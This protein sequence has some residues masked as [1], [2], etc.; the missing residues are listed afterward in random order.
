M[1]ESDPTAGGAGANG[2]GPAKA[3]IVKHSRFSPIWLIP[4]IAL[5]VAA[6]VAYQAIATRG[7][8]VVV[9]F[10]EAQGIKEG[11]SVVKFRD[12]AV[13]TVDSI[14]FRD[15]DHIELHL[16]LDQAMAP[17]LIEGSN[18]WV[19]RPRFGGG[20]ISGLETIVSGSFVTFEP[21][22]KSGG[23]AKREYVGLEDP[24]LPA[25]ERP[26][27]P[28]LLHTDNVGG[29]EAGS[30]IFY[31][32]VH[33][34]DVAHVGLS[35][36]GSKVDIRAV[37][38]TTHSKLVKRTSTFWN[39]G[40]VEMSIGSGGIDVKT[41][42]LKSFLIG[43][44]AF[45]S[46]QH[47]QLAKKG[48]AFW[49]N[50]SHAEAKMV[51]QTHGGLRLVLETPA[52]GGVNAGNP[53]YYREVP[54]GAVLSHELSKDGSTVRVQI[55]IHHKYEALVRSNT[56]F[57]NASG[58]SANLGLTGLH[59]HAESLKALLEGGIAFATPPQPK[60]TVSAG[61]VFELHPEVKDD[62]LKWTADYSPEAANES[63]QKK[64]KGH[65]FHHK[66]KDEEQAK[67]DDA[68]PEPTADEKKHHFMHGLFHH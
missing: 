36:D 32:D 30:P 24:P 41:E 52:L 34:G 19:V 37:I 9:V 40:G 29:L 59:I 55:N 11:K 54:V 51:K 64:K 66:D 45:D 7:I 50:A 44:I 49:L 13:G 62:W 39:A 46:P 38:E 33:V 15:A 60:H 68:T 47:G 43:G 25:S 5:V 21:S 10:D 63:Q 27:L 67:Q 14:S 18:W 12:I 65:W 57:W 22:V 56:V 58:I 6:S 53:V 42:S 8:P 20:A 3:V 28:I 16:S 4:I 31:R 2:G 48:D 23:A 26:G 1:S 35:E 61:S 17:F